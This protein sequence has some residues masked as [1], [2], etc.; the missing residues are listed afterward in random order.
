MQI[1]KANLRMN[2]IPNVNNHPNKIIIHHPVFNGSVVSLNELMISMGYCMI[3]YNYYVRK[4]GSVWEGRPVKYEGGNCLGQNRQSIGVCC[5]GDFD[6]ETMGAKQLNALVE[7]CQYLKK[8][9]G[10]SEVGPHMKYSSTDCPGKYFPIN[11][12]L[13]KINGGT[14]TGSVTVTPSTEDDTLA[15]AACYVGERCKELQTKLTAL[16]YE[17]GGIDGIFGSKTFTAVKAFQKDNGLTVDGFAGPDTFNALNDTVSCNHKAP[18]KDEIK[19]LQSILNSI[20]NTGLDIDG[21][22]GPLT[23]NA[24]DKVLVK[25]RDDYSTLTKWI[26]NRLLHLGYSVGTCGADGY[27]GEGTEGT[28]R[29]FQSNHGLTADGVVGKLTMIKLLHTSET[30]NVNTPSVNVVKTL[31]TALIQSGI[32]L[33]KFGADGDYGSETKSA[34]QKVTITKGSGYTILV[35]WIQSRLNSLGYSIGSYGVDGDFGSGTLNAVKLFQSN[36]GLTSDGIVGIN[37][38]E[39]LIKA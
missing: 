30:T 12:A 33:P 39:N 15:K 25:R 22:I 3:G 34:L 38:W 4:D 5:E 20:Y 29:K 13:A 23:I 36:H 35:K 19:D 27:F 11:E 9:Y 1:Q 24:L 32:S 28:V 8:Q 31:Q 17:C 7:L 16:G 14:Y 26:Q 21:I 10:I 6:H 18:S 2:G 37:T